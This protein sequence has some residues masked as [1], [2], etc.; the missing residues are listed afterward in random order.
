[1]NFN[2]QCLEVTENR[3]AAPVATATRAT[4]ATST[5]HAA[6]PVAN[7]AAVAV[8]PPLGMA[9]CSACS[10]FEERP[11][12]SPDGW[13]RRLSV[14]T[15]AAP[16]FECASYRPAEA[17]L[18]SQV[19]RRA[20]VVKRLQADASLR[21]SFDVQ[22]ASPIAPASAA[23][24]VMLGLRTAAGEIVTGELTVPPERWPGVG[25]FADYWRTAAEERPS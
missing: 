13:C 18:V 17:A 9:R 12:E 1:M 25:T 4:T 7:V 24:S 21:Y 19:R 11:G 22:G 15:W 2:L 16:L 10:H 14:E 6:Q 3:E 5:P 8:A 23:V 20:A